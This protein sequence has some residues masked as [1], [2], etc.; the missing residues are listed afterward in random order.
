MF[1]ALITAIDVSVYQ[2]NGLCT[3]LC[4][5]Q[6]AFAILQ[7]QNCWCSNYI[8]ATTTTGCSLSCPGYPF[9]KCGGEGLYGYIALGKVAPSGTLGASTEL[10]T[11]PQTSTSTPTSSPLQIPPQVSLR[12]LIF[13]SFPS[14][15]GILLR[16]HL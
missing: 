11:Q 16:S 9:E 7:D 1:P 2:S 14:G 3:N 6:Y 4:I 12:A 13:N 5:Q 15:F 8:P 10:S